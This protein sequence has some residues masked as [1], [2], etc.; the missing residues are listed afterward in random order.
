[1]PASTEIADVRWLTDTSLCPACRSPLGGPRCGVCG[2][3]LSGPEGQRLWQLSTEAARALIER[4]RV[5][6]HLRTV[7]AAPHAAA[8]VE[9]AVV[10]RHAGRVGAK[11]PAQPPVQPPAQVQRANSPAGGPGLHR[12][13]VGIGALLLSVGALGFLAFSWR[14]L[15]LA[16]RAAVIAGCT[17]A[18]LALAARLRPRLAETAEAVGAFGVA[19]VLGDAWAV[20]RTGL[21][22]ADR[23]AVLTY[24]AAAAGL[25]ALLLVAWAR[26]GRVRAGSIAAAVLGPLAVVLAGARATQVTGSSRE[27]A[28][29]LLVAAGLAAGR[30]ALP[31]PLRAERILLRLTACAGVGLGGLLAVTSSGMGHGPGF[32]I[33]LA[34]AGTAALQAVVDRERARMTGIWAAAAGL[35]GVAGGVPAARLVTDITSVDQSWLLA[36]V[37][38][39]SGVLLLALLALVR[40]AVWARDDVTRPAI[41]AGAV[42]SAIT[43]VPGAA[44]AATATVLATLLGLLRPWDATGSTGVAAAERAAGL[45]WYPTQVWL[46]AALGLLAATFALLAVVRSRLVDGVAAAAAATAVCAVI[47]LPWAPR[48]MLDAA[49][50]LEVLVA[51]ALAGVAASR[52]LPPGVAAVGWTASLAAGTAAVL[53]AWAVRPLSVPVTLAGAAGLLLARRAVRATWVRTVLVAVAAVASLVAVGAC[54][55]LAGRG[56]AD[57]FTLGGVA[58]ALLAAAVL[59]VPGQLPGQLPGWPP[60]SRM[61]WT[62]GERLAAAAPGVLAVVAALPWAV[63]DSGLPDRHLRVLLGVALVCVLAIASRPRAD[64]AGRAPWL[65]PTAAF[66]ATPIAATTASSIAPD[67]PAVVLAA[68]AAAAG[69]ALAVLALRGLDDVRRPAAEL[70]VGVVGVAALVA[71]PGLDELW[72]VLLLLGAGTAAD[73]ATPGRH[74][75]GWAAGLL[76]TGSTWARLAAAD[77]GTVEA[78]TLPPA[79]ALLAVAALRLR[80]ERRRSE[81]PRIA[82]PS[83]AGGPAGPDWPLV[84]RTVAPGVG[85]ALGPSILACAGGADLRPAVLLAVAAALVG[86]AAVVRD[87]APAGIPALGAVLLGSGAAA[88]AGSAAVRAATGLHAFRDRTAVPV[89]AV[90]RWTLPA[91][92]VLAAA[93]V[94]ACLP[95][96]RRQTPGVDAAARLAAVPALAMAG[97]PSLAAALHPSHEGVR[98]GAVLAGAGAVSLAATAL[99]RPVWLPTAYAA[100]ALA[101]AAALTGLVTSAGP[102]AEVWTLPVGALLLVLG[103][104]RMA[105]TPARSWPALGPGLAV[106]LLPSLV[107]ASDDGVTWRAV[108]L[109]ALAAGTTL[110]G[111]ARRLQAPLLFGAGVL[112]VHAVVHL[113]PWVARWYVELHL[114][115]S[116]ALAGALLLFLGATYE[117]SLRQLRSAGLRLAA[118]R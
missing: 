92:A 77:V 83:D 106:T 70:G 75:L 109:V 84:W 52:R 5:L 54:A 16:G 23:P 55:G 101:V 117:R 116:L 20:R 113:A 72:I 28:V 97:L 59:T 61:P 19:L 71:T 102:A 2:V 53:A 78:Y 62:A 25:V 13:L 64:V 105:R 18:V 31:S 14:V 108:A 33:T 66:L 118:L 48:L 24:A 7:T 36:L 85:L 100:T 43:A 65:A 4:E 56:M 90:E 44:V 76:L 95:W 41:A 11:L 51:A 88:A 69:L 29:S 87:R 107:L 79:A 26:L 86:L 3:D 15:S 82:G 68:V 9:R 39:C 30:R 63:E 98:A 42:L 40:I 12:V 47:L 58:G 89:S 46:A 21:L 91:A 73:A 1:M 34:A 81:R 110:V 112:A 111:A 96:V 57:R 8:H 103:A 38:A 115:V 27:L 45:P 10:P 60:R 49:V 74:R 35:I 80:S 67:R 94:V 17:V 37:P 50:P 6:E 22:G 99:R 32:A 93:G 114:W 104:D